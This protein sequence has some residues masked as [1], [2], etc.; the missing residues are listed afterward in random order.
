MNSSSEKRLRS[1]VEKVERR[2]VLQKTEDQ[3]HASS[4]NHQ[5][6]QLQQE[7]TEE[8]QN[9]RAITKFISGGTLNEIEKKKTQSSALESHQLKRKEITERMQKLSESREILDYPPQ[10][11]AATAAVRKYPLD[12]N[13]AHTSM[14]QINP[15]GTRPHTP[16]PLLPPTF[17]PVTSPLRPEQRHHKNQ[18]ERQI[19]SQSLRSEGT[20]SPE[21]QYRALVTGSGSY[22]SSVGEIQTVVPDEPKPFYRKACFP[23]NINCD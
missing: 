17:S 12:W 23:T 19:S 5:M 4:F 15:L 2:P 13:F 3:S 6:K 11:A 18:I 21:S 20:G 16:P 8:E 14:G 7:L 9:Y 10:H 1:G 22:L